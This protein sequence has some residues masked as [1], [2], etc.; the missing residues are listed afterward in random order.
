MSFTQVTGETCSRQHP[1]RWLSSKESAYQC[2]PVQE[3]GVWSQGGE[4]S[5][6]EEMATRCSILAQEIPHEQSVHWKNAWWWERLKAE[7]EEGDRD[8][9]F[10]RH[11]QFNGSEL[12]QTEGGSERQGGLACCSPW[13][14]K[15][16]YTTQWLNS[17]ARWLM[18]LQSLGWKDALEKEMAI[19]FSTLA[20]EIPWTEEPGGL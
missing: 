4:D 10:G 5:P 8:E 16:S 17:N 11:H 2:L 15:A 6:E 20:W 14:Y 12:G 9:M 3:T 19:P 1:S 18:R 13:G 7:G